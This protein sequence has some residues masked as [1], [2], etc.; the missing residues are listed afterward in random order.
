MPE[1]L[2]LQCEKPFVS[3]PSYPKKGVV[4]KRL[5]CSKA[6][7]R[8]YEKESVPHWTCETCSKDFQRNYQWNSKLKEHQEPRFCGDSCYREWQKKNGKSLGTFVRGGD[9]WN[10]GMKGLCHPGSVATQFQ[11]GNR[12]Q[13]YAP[14]GTV[15]ERKDSKGKNRLQAYIKVA[16]P[17]VWKARSLIVW[18]EHNGQLAEGLLL[19]HTDGNSL[20]DDI[21]N[22]EAITRAENLARVRKS[23]DPVKLSASK[24]AAWARRRNQ[25]AAQAAILEAEPEYIEPEPEEDEFFV[26]LKPPPVKPAKS[27]WCDKC[28][29]LRPIGEFLINDHHR[30]MYCPAKQGYL[31]NTQD[32]DKEKAF[33]CP[34][35]KYLYATRE[36]AEA[37]IAAVKEGR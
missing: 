17:N 13:T 22:L 36:E 25:P 16:D 31:C 18:E 5:F 8:A 28:E 21:G 27:L 34:S 19:Y 20:N 29:E 30:T 11:P 33:R 9:P 37:A 12:P 26:S 14:V 7:Q 23:L 35:L 32:C 2:C 15:I 4:K 6:C 3:R 24:K 1:Y 10:K